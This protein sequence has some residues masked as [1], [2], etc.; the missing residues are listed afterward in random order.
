MDIG[1]KSHLHV[2]PDGLQRQQIGVVELNPPRARRIAHQFPIEASRPR[3]RGRLLI[4][5]EIDMPATVHQRRAGPLAVWAN[6]A[7]EDYTLVQQ[8]I[9]DGD[10]SPLIIRLPPISLKE[11]L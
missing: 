3:Q 7:H 2:R 8:R 5:L 1:I 4:R 11:P 9:D 10:Q 6:D